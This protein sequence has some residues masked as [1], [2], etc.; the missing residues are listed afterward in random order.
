MEKNKYSEFILDVMAWY[1]QKIE[2]LEEGSVNKLRL[3]QSLHMCLIIKV[4]K[5]ADFSLQKKEKLLADLFNTELTKEVM[6]L[7]EERSAQNE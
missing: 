7:Q 5:F 3:H 2:E 1:D 4:K 6:K